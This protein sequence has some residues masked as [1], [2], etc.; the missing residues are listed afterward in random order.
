MEGLGEGFVDLLS[1]ARYESLVL[2]D[3]DKE[4]INADLAREEFDNLFFRN[5]LLILVYIDLK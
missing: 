1:L 3:L 4:C 2:R 5:I